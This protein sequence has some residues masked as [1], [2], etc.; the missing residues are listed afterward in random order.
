MKN[1]YHLIGVL[2]VLAVTTTQKLLAQSEIQRLGVLDTCKSYNLELI[3]VSN[4]SM[5]D[6]VPIWSSSGKIAGWSSMNG[7]IKEIH[8]DGVII[9]TEIVGP[10]I[11]SQNSDN[12]ITYG[13]SNVHGGGKGLMWI[14]CYSRNGRIIYDNDGLSIIERLG[15]RNS[16]DGGIVFAA[17]SENTGPECQDSRMSLVKMNGNG[18]IER[19]IS[20][21][22]LS[23]F[24]TALLEIKGSDSFVFSGFN[25]QRNSYES[26]LIDFGF[27]NVI[28][29]EI[30][31]GWL[32]SILSKDRILYVNIDKGEWQVHPL[33]PESNKPIEQG[34][35]LNQ[36]FLS[37]N[38]LGS[39]TLSYIPSN[40]SIVISE[41]N[42]ERGDSIYVNIINIDNSCQWYGAIETNSPTMNPT[43]GI[44]II[45]E[46]GISYCLMNTVFKIEMK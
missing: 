46:F 1:Y 26:Y 10:V 9:S 41:F 14:E 43:I 17:L 42:F 27:N 22:C 13:Y 29:I 40:R 45:R 19:S 24:S 11:I 37:K 33:I 4:D 36:N 6:A 18:K 15:V 32:F 44:P 38:V 23:F 30:K 28:P 8:V 39:R 7:A 25:E 16:Q 3:E 34:R 2:F 20:L 35:F 12:I 21:P 31:F 5:K